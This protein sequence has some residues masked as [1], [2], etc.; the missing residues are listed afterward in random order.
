MNRTENGVHSCC[1]ALPERLAANRDEV[2]KSVRSDRRR[3]ADD[4]LAHIAG[5]ACLVGSD[6]G[7]LPLDGEGPSR[8]VRIRPFAI[9]RHAVTNTDFAAFVDATAYRTDAERFGYSYVF[10][11]FLP[12]ERRRVQRVVGAEWWCRIEAAWW[13]EPEGPGSSFDECASHPVVHVSWNDAK[14]YAAWSGGRLPSEAEWEFAARGGLKGNRFPWGDQEPDNVF[15]PCNIWQGTFPL[16]NSGVDGYLGTAPVEAFPPNG[17]GLHNTVG[18]VWEWCAD[19][20]RVRSLQRSAKHTN[21]AA[22][23]ESQRVIKGGSYLC[24]RSYCYRYRIAARQGVS[25]DS[26][27]GHLGFRLAFDA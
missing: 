9:A 25:P 24:H 15:T 5:G 22:R 21:H 13:R 16:H 10:E 18:N 6:D 7:L 11:L 26:S 20:F 1:V 19:S 2:T 8:M 4:R 12:E 17:Y 3:I 14:A 27:T 23:R